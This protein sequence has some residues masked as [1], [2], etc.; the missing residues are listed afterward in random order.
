[1]Q[2]EIRKATIADIPIIRELSE[3]I[4]KRHYIEIISIQQIE[5]MLDKMYSVKKL[6]E[7]INHTD[8]AYF[9][10]F[11]NNELAGY[12]AISSSD[13]K[14]FMLHKF[15]IL[16]EKRFKGIGERVFNLVFQSSDSISLFVN[17]QNYKSVNFYF[18]MGFKIDDVI[19]N[20]IG[21]GYFMNDFIMKKVSDEK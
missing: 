12:I 7:E 14:N 5:Y 20:N 17:R 3:T 4:W 11:V 1:M 8:Y 16:A 9:I 2:V 13:K 19:D 15:Y 18:K 10:A 6:E 21:D